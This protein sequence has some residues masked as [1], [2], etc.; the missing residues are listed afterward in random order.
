MDFTEITK[1]KITFESDK[2][3]IDTVDECSRQLLT[4]DENLIKHQ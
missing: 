4:P 2:S 3:D 1:I